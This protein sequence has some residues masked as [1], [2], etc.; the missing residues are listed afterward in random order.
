MK[1][2]QIHFAPNLSKTCFTAVLSFR[3]VGSSGWPCDLEPESTRPPPFLLLLTQV[4]DLESGQFP[5]VLPWAHKSPEGLTLYLPPSLPRQGSFSPSSSLTFSKWTNLWPHDIDIL[6]SWGPAK[7][8]PIHQSPSL[9]PLLPPDLT[10]P[11]CPQYP[12][13]RFSDTL[14]SLVIFFEVKLSSTLTTETV[15]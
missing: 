8:W 10:L 9:V 4:Q 12:N 5:Q 7:F 3:L 14:T 11:A 13:S 6:L 2:C 1:F 15:R